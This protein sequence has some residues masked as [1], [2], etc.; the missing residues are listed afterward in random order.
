MD[1]AFLFRSL[2]TLGSDKDSWSK[3][4]LKFPPLV[5]DKQAQDFNPGRHHF[6]VQILGA[7][8]D[9]R[10][11]LLSTVLGVHERTNYTQEQRR[12]AL[13]DARNSIHS[14]VN[15]AIKTVG[16][17][18]DVSSAIK[19]AFDRVNKILK[20]NTLTKDITIA[21]DTAAAAA[22]ATQQS[23]MKAV[24]EPFGERVNDIL[25]RLAKGADINADYKQFV[26]TVLK[27]YETLNPTAQIEQIRQ[28]FLSVKATGSK[29]EGVR[30]AS[31]LIVTAV[32]VAAAAATACKVAKALDNNY[33]VPPA[34]GAFLES[35]NGTTYDSTEGVVAEGVVA[36]V[37]TAVVAA[38]SAAATAARSRP[39]VAADAARVA[40]AAKLAKDGATYISRFTTPTSTPTSTDGIADQMK[41]IATFAAKIAKS[42][43]NDDDLL[44]HATLMESLVKS[45]NTLNQ[46]SATA[47]G[48]E[49]FYTQ[50][51]RQATS[52]ERTTRADKE[53]IVFDLENDELHDPRT[54]K[55]NVTDRI[56]FVAT[57]FVLRALAN[58]MVQWAIQINMLRTFQ[59]AFMFY[60]GV[61]VVLFM[62]WVALVNTTN[63]PQIFRLLFWY[64]SMDNG[65]FR[66]ILHV[67]LQ[68]I[69]LPIP[70]LVNEPTTTD[71]STDLTFE[72]KHGL[73]KSIDTFSIFVWIFVSMIAFV[74]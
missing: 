9:P 49:P 6:Y 39:A 69:L 28:S 11:A 5:S 31:L 65:P 48:A 44:R 35:L 68:I 15:D 64:T 21:N 40:N 24:L 52:H 30:A 20:A 54:G 50:L 32:K 18:G 29:D 53:G 71:L 63:S 61:Y 37:V 60:M 1:L 13:I 27:E 10:E 66:L 22:A 56:V 55:I 36:N 47:G 17:D 42:N 74:Y 59:A 3:W 70:Y 38:E 19:A 23:P 46:A 45:L 16:P 43:P 8:M 2:V 33:T 51:L 12:T 34:L 57:T 4:W 41:S 26:N 7:L 67:L 72:Q 58:F 14:I 73:A 25:D 62:L